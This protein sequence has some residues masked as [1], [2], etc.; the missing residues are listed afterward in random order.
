MEKKPFL[1]K[2]LTVLALILF[3][4]TIFIPWIVERNLTLT[5]SYFW[6]FMVHF[7]WLEI[8]GWPIHKFIFHDDWFF[9]QDFWFKT[10]GSSYRYLTGPSNPYGLYLGWLCIF[11][12]QISTVVLWLVHLFKP[13]FLKKDLCIFGVIILPF[14]SLFLGVHQCLVQCG[15]HYHSSYQPQVFPYFGF[16]LTVVSV[17][18]LLISFRKA[19]EWTSLKR[20]KT[21]KVALGV[22]LVCVLGF[23]VVNELEF[24]TRVT[25]LMVIERRV[26]PEELPGDP[27]LWEGDFNR[28]VAVADIFRARVRY[29]SP[30]YYH[31]ELEVPVISYEI[32]M[33]I[34]NSMGYHAHEPTFLYIS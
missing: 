22:F 21:R 33:V 24:Q 12:C 7:N 31:C 4:S 2:R 26:K 8:R 6:S 17:A 19:P 13:A 28:I 10:F 29:N 16:W 9:F 5:P 3:A 14:V 34:Y 20:F 30:K 32:L 15:I 25:K 1:R 11:V 23:F 27:E 18:L